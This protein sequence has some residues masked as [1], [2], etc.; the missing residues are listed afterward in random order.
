MADQEGDLAA[1]GMTGHTYA[2]AALCREREGFWLRLFQG[3]VTGK[4]FEG[5]AEEICTA[6][7][8]CH[9]NQVFLSMELEENGTYRFFWSEKGEDFQP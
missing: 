1:L 9:G 7:I 5:E 8:P 4:E 6:S 2:Y 3:R